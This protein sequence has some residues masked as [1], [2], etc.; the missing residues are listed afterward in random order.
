MSDPSDVRGQID[1]IRRLVH[2]PS[3]EERRASRVI[4]MLWAGLTG[5]AALG[6]AAM[7]SWGVRTPAAYA[8][9]WVAHNLV[10]WSVTFL[11]DRR[12]VRES[13]RDSARGRRIASVW[14][15]VNLAVWLCVW[16]S[17]G[18]GWLESQ[19]INPVIATLLGTGIVVTGL[20][21][22]SGRMV[23]IGVAGAVA[24]AVIPGLVPPAI[25][26]QTGCLLLV[27]P[28]AALALPLGRPRD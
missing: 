17:F 8:L 11:L 6:T 7:A 26:F 5:A 23:W 21:Y 24:G 20:L 12:R 18:P 15:M 1:E 14:A 2:Q 19:A 3:D 10:G 22:E 13:G 4:A 28:L 9:V 25:A 16:Q 27:A